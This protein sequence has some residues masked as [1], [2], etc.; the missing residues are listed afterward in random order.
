[1][2][3]ERIAN[4]YTMTYF[5]ILSLPHNLLCFFLLYF[6]IYRC[7]SSVGENPGKKLRRFKLIQWMWIFLRL[8]S[9]AKLVALLLLK[10]SPAVLPNFCAIIFDLYCF[11]GEN[12]SSWSWRRCHQKGN[13]HVLS[14]YRM[15][16][17]SS[18]T[19]YSQYQN[20][21][22]VAAEQ[23]YHFYI[24]Y[25]IWLIGSHLYH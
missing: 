7:P 22:I 4:A 10:I 9:A 25:D 21:C 24:K 13:Q 18:C 11:T 16:R 6:S 19:A 5:I 17:H 12:G 1:M 2:L 15:I 3:L 8:K 23:N 20:I 14:Y